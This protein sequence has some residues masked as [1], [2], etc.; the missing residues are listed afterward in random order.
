MTTE[1]K[2]IIVTWHTADVLEVAKN[3]NIQITDEQAYM[4]LLRAGIDHD[5]CIGINWDVIEHH[6][7]EFLDDEEED[8]QELG[9]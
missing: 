2:S 4:V 6:L 5:P 7:D 3:R 9:E 1:N 8:K